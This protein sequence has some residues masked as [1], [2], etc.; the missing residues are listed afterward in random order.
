MPRAVCSYCG[1]RSKD[2]PATLYLAWYTDE[3]DRVSYLI[4]SCIECL[5][6]RWKPTLATYNSVS[7]DSSTCI[8]CGGGLASDDST[9]FLNL[10]LPKQ[11]GR[12]FDLDFDAACAA[13]IC[14]DT[15]EFGKR[16]P[17]RRAQGE[18]PQAPQPSP[19][20]GLEL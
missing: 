5:V 20:D 19:W 18:G 10:Y 9:V 16:L 15:S 2:K 11:E 4:R 17:D 14:G 6:E 3:G 12:A 13:R 8:G 7:T 1:E